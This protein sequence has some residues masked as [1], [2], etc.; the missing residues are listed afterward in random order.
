MG[1][2]SEGFRRYAEDS[3]RLYAGTA[4]PDQPTPRTNPRRSARTGN[5]ASTGR[6]L[7]R[8]RCI[9]IP[10]DSKA[11]WNMSDC[12]DGHQTVYNCTEEDEDTPEVIQGIISPGPAPST[13]PRHH[14]ILTVL[15]VTLASPRPAPSIILRHQAFPTASL[16][17]LRH[18]AYLAVTLVILYHSRRI[19]ERVQRPILLSK[20]QRTMNL[21]STCPTG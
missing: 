17:H 14:V 15:L 3:I 16:T 12:N 13:V 20:R 8:V 11:S 7:H 18:Q 1:G 2:R 21:P 6:I 10:G 9:H 5:A 19:R 4:T